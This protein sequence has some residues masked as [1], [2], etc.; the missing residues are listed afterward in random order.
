[1]IIKISP[2]TLQVKCQ[3]YS[4]S[5]RTRRRHRCCWQHRRRRHA[6]G[7]VERRVGDASRCRHN[8][9]LDVDDSCRRRAVASRL[10]QLLLVRL[11]GVQLFILLLV[12]NVIHLS[13]N[14][15]DD[16]I[17]QKGRVDV[18]TRRGHHHRPHQQLTRQLPS[19]RTQYE[20][21]L[22]HNHTVT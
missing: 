19:P 1:M 11:L 17:R 16:I 12:N 18:A 5:N 8:D 9:V 14:R 3:R 22:N 15:H 21:C 7:L 4:H 10:L 13:I 20:H 6:P 2:T